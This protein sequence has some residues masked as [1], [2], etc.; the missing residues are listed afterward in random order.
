MIVEK[1]IVIIDIEKL[2]VIIEKELKI[3]LYIINISNIL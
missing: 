2:V 3:Y 1:V